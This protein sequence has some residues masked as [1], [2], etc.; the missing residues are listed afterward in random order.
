MTC[1]TSPVLDDISRASDSSVTALGDVGGLSW[2]LLALLGS[3]IDL[4]G[5][6]YLPSRHDLLRLHMPLSSL[7]RSLPVLAD[8][9][10]FSHRLGGCGA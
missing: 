9:S 1:D 6:S 2:G 7:P 8:R 3:H 10:P 5:E 4:I